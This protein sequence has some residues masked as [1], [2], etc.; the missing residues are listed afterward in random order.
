MKQFSKNSAQMKQYS[1]EGFSGYRVS[2]FSGNFIPKSLDRTH[3]RLLQP[4]QV[5][6][7]HF[8]KIVSHE[9]V[10]FCTVY[11]PNGLQRIRGRPYSTSCSKAG[12]GPRRFD[13]L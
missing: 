4:E 9:H 12:G 1:S 11:T 5:L 10:H 13:G 8:H 6:V 7:K 3:L 2:S